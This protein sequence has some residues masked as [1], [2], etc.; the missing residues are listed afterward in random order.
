MNGPSNHYIGLVTRYLSDLGLD[1]EDA[2]HHGYVLATSTWSLAGE[3]AIAESTRLRGHMDAQ[4]ETVAR[5]EGRA[6]SYWSALHFYA[7]CGDEEFD[8]GLRAREVIGA[9]R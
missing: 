6:V 3:E 9:Q 2:R 8:G 7:L 5:A 1:E 4:R